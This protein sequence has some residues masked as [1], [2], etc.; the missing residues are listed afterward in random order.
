MCFEVILIRFEP[1]GGHF[2]EKFIFEY[3]SVFFEVSILPNLVWGISPLGFE[4][5]MLIVAR[6]HEVTSARTDLFVESWPFR[7]FRSLY[8]LSMK[9]FL[10]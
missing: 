6:V 10:I 4:S 9:L 7:I 2:I 3:R 1:S 5:S 8:S